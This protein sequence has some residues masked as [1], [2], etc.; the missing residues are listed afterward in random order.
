M[1]EQPSELKKLVAI[2]SDLEL[3]TE[4]RAKAI[5][6][7]S[8]IGNY[9][10]LLGLLDLA[11]NESLTKKERDLALQQAREIIKSGH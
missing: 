10:A 11:A 5:K 2:A 4:L 3:P 1:S 6:Q 9:E 8:N 7:L